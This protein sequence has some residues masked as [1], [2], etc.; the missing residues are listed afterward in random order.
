MLLGQSLL[1]R[2]FKLRLLGV[3]LRGDELRFGLID[4]GALGDDLPADA[5]DGCLLGRGLVAR[6]LDG[7]PIIA[8]V[9]GGDDI[10]GLYP[11][12][13][14]HRNAVDIARNL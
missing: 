11:G 13:V 7:K 3:S 6:C 4:S 2:E 10:A 5:V 1:P 9:D 12:I 8:I 14:R